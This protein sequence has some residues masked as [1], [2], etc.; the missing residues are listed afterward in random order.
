MFTAPE[1]Y[2]FVSTD[3]S[4][5]E[6]R[7][8]AHYLNKKYDD[9]SMTDIFVAGV[10]M[11]QANADNW[12]VSRADAKTGLYAILYSAGATTVGKGDKDKGTEKNLGFPSPKEHL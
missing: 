3:L 11:H 12:G 2:A 6:A 7:V 9:T 10:D 1:G 8:L 5:I 4:A